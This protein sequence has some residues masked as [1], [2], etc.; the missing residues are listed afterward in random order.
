MAKKPSHI[1]YHVQE[2]GNNT[3]TEKSKGHW[4]KIGAAWLHK[5]G[6]GLDVI[7]DLIPAAEPRLVLRE[8]EE[9]PQDAQA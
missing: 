1:V 6:K 9:R 8:W 2:K 5:D 3:P 4:T 7:L